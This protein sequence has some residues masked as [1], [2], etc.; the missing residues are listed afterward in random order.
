MRME[1]SPRTLDTLSEFVNIGAGKAANALN[2]LLGSHVRLNVP[3]VKF[4][5][6]AS[7][8]T[9][10]GLGSGR[11][12]I[13]MDFFGDVKGRAILV[14]DLATTGPL[15]ELVAGGETQDPDG[16]LRMSVLTEIGNIVINAI[17]GSIS[18]M[19]HAN[20]DYS[21]PRSIEFTAN[22]VGELAVTAAFALKAETTFVLE[23]HAI[24]AEGILL[25]SSSSFAEHFLTS[26]D[27]C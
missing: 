22:G 5:P 13:V 6:G 2:M 11:R 21:V 9:Q 3:S 24:S 25:F 18:N 19:V 16:E 27:K 12:G 14:F 26:V 10:V 15:L 1:T 20:I 7:W 23:Q 17:V 8:H 4:L